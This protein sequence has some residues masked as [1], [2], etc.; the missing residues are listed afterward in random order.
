MA[1]ANPM[2]KEIVEKLP[3]EVSFELGD[4]FVGLSLPLAEPLVFSFV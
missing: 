4:K 1:G 3:D 2:S